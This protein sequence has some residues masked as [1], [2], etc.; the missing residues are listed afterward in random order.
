MLLT[1]T[2][3]PSARAEAATE[4]PK[5]QPEHR[6]DTNAIETRLEIEHD[7]GSEQCPNADDVFQ[8]IGTLFPERSYVRWT[9]RS[10]DVRAFAHIKIRPTSLGHEAIVEVT[11][12]R[13]GERIILENDVKCNGLADALAVT[14]VMLMDLTVDPNSV[15]TTQFAPAPNIQPTPAPEVT[16]TTTIKP[17]GSLEAKAFVNPTRPLSSTPVSTT[18][19]SIRSMHLDA[20]V[21]GIGGLGL[22]SEPALGAAI[23]FDL[24]H[25]AGWGFTIQGQK[26]WS[27]PIQAETGKLTLS[28]WGVLGGPCF[29]QSLSTHSKLYT[30]LNFGAGA[31]HAKASNYQNAKTQDVPWAVVGPSLR[32]ST[33]MAQN[34]SIFF[35][36]GFAV[37]LI[38]QSFSVTNSDGGTNPIADARRTAFF[39]ELGLSV[40][41]L[42]FW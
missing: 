19:S 11:Q 5:H 17:K 21:N 41:D 20:R 10:T 2:A 23:G 1:V 36:L 12:P 25:H 40:D 39:A 31:E 32:W 16:A 13:I 30:C 18:T 3:L 42:L 14:L 8:A 28:L 26:L 34:L 29:R 9:G 35:G 6:N 7:A 38:P 15:T 24:F 27:N 37:Q 33:N 22:L 4:A